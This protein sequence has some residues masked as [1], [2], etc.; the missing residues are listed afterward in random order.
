MTE[1]NVNVADEL[2]INDEDVLDEN[3]RSSH[4]R[5]S[6]KIGVLKNFAK[7]TGKRLCQR[8]FFNKVAD[9]RPEYTF[10][11]RTPPNDCFWNK[12]FILLHAGNNYNRLSFPRWK[13]ARISLN[14]PNN[15]EYLLDFWFTKQDIIGLCHVFG[16]S[17]TKKTLNRPVVSSVETFCIVPRWSAYPC[18]YVIWFSC[19]LDLSLTF[20]SYLIK[21]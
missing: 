3:D 14:L 7:L 4:R 16:L 8:L 5:C 13:Y 9:L 21:C 18:R 11:Y 10:F 1:V 2:D 15:N 17:D 12:L 6:I 20:R 19:F